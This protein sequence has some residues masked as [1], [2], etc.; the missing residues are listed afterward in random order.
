MC[1]SGTTGETATSDFEEGFRAELVKALAEPDQTF[2][3]E[4]Q[5]ATQ[6]NYQEELQGALKEKESQED[7]LK[8]A[9]MPVLHRTAIRPRGVEAYEGHQNREHRTNR[10]AQTGEG[11]ERVAQEALAGQGGG[12]FVGEDSQTCGQEALP[13]QVDTLVNGEESQAWGQDMGMSVKIEREPEVD[14]E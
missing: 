12:T 11:A 1:G 3:V 8:A 5:S 9:A 2:E 10:W 7:G 4:Q 13:G 6:D 14:F